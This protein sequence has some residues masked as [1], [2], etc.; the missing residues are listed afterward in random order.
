[1]LI[2][3][4]STG[5]KRQCPWTVAA[6]ISIVLR[7]MLSGSAQKAVIRRRT[8]KFSTTGHTAAT[9]TCYVAS[10]QLSR[11]NSHQPADDAGCWET[12]LRSV[13]PQRPL[14][15]CPRSDYRERQHYRSGRWRSLSDRSY[16]PRCR[17]LQRS[18]WL[19]WQATRPRHH[20]WTVCGYVGG[21]NRCR[22]QRSDRLYRVGAL[23]C[24]VQGK[25]GL[26]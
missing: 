19:R 14:C 26:L 17:L 11:L 20:L 21:M 7:S 24:D 6:R 13:T 2:P 25:R 1:V 18:R 8:S 15:G 16:R 4:S 22:G 23:N 9:G 12:V 3:S 10:W 5:H